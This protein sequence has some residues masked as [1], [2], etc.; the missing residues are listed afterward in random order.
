MQS[1]N[2][3]S[4]DNGLDTPVLFLVFNRPEPTRLVFE[5]I[6]EARP[7][8]LYV[9]CDG[10]RASRFSDIEL[11]AQV[12]SLITEGIDWPC[13]LHTFFREQNLGCG[14][15]VSAAI[16]WFFEHEP[17][18][19]I[20]EDDCLPGPDFFR[21]SQELLTRY[22]HDTRI[23][24]IG[25]NNYSNEAKL[26]QPIDGQSYFFSGHVQSWGWAT[27]RRAWQLYDFRFSLLPVLRRQKLLSHIYP[28]LIEREYWLRKFERMRLSLHPHS[29]HDTWDYQWHFTITSN[30]GLTIVPLV[31]MVQNI[32]FGPD[33]THTLNTEDPYYAREARPILFP[34]R[35]PAAVLRDWNRDREYFN[36]FLLSRLSF[37]W[38]YLLRQL[39][40]W[41]KEQR[42]VPQDTPYPAEATPQSGL[43]TVTYSQT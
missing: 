42:T 13:E 2:S 7:P 37:K 40:D 34:L 14:L 20:L 8:R 11:C 22:R 24:H 12:R 32:G 33:A 5:A 10:P 28:S 17:E 29:L 19:I 23:M 15:N 38:K 31:N 43:S 4:A 39:P 21:F 30:S 6:R 1:Y 16:T 25:G 41:I 36:E 35:H 27:W 9:A 26:P 3:P 18:G